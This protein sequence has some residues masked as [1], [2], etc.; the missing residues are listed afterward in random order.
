M[1]AT[2]ILAALALSASSPVL[3]P[4]SVGAR[5]GSGIPTAARLTMGVDRVV[6]LI[7][8]VG[9]SGRTVLVLDAT[10]LS[11]IDLERILHAVDD[12]RRRG[13]GIVA[14]VESA[15]GAG[16]LAALACTSI[17]PIES[18]SLETIPSD[19]CT[20]PSRREDLLADVGELGDI[21]ASLVRRLM[22]E[23]LD[24]SW[25]LGRG[26]RP[27]LRG[28]VRVSVSGS[29]LTLDAEDLVATGLAARTHASVDEIIAM[30]Q[31]DGIPP[32]RRAI[33]A[34]RS[35]SVGRSTVAD[36]PG[37][38]SDA[39]KA[40]MAEYDA[41]LARLQKDLLE[42]HEYFTGR[43]GVWT[44]ARSLQRV[45]ERTS[46]QTRHMDTKLTCERLQ[47]SILGSIGDLGTTGRKLRIVLRDNNHPVMQQ[48]RR[49]LEHLDGL[50]AAFRRNRADD[51]VRHSSA[52]R[53]MRPISTAAR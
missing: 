17:A 21:D 15:H 11:D 34:R 4:Q 6:E 52:I 50:E 25:S 32:R 22:G 30:S 31:R 27:D 10:A 24:V 28:D 45:W 44:H 14:A 7:D 18:F 40:M 43:K 20:S 16:L 36:E 46:E 1:T 5:P 49:D 51:Y 13:V 35:D 23:D 33:E 3:H 9:D 41:I 48:H 47:K 26:F 29:A 8:L 37:G 2:T 53:V 42:F 38:T 12:A 39:A 19:W